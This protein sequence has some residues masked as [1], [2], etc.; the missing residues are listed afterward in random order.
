M[1]RTRQASKDPCV[2]AID[3]GTTGIKVG[4]FTAAGR[5]LA[6]ASREQR[7][8]FPGPGMVEQDP[9][10]TWQLQC[11]AVRE[12]VTTA[13]VSREAVA[14]LALSVQRGTVIAIDPDGKPL[15]NHIVWMDKR[16]VRQLDRL[17]EQLGAEAY[18]DI[19]GHPLVPYAG[20][21]KVLWLRHE[22]PEIFSRCRVVAPPQTLYLRWMGA[23]EWVCDTSAGTFFFPFEIRRVNWSNELLR[24][25]DVPGQKLPR[26]VP[27][28]TV[29]GT[30]SRG[31]AEACGLSPGTKVVAGGGDG[32][33]AAVGSGVT[34]AGRVMV[35]I[36][37][38]A[39]VQVFLPQPRLDPQRVLNCGAHVIPDAWEMEAHTQASGAVFRW[40]R[41][42]LGREELRQGAR[43][44]R[45]A[46]D[47]LIEQ[48]VR[49]P[50]GADGLMMLPTLNGSSAPVMRPAFKGAILGLRLSHTRAHLIRAL[51][52]GV[53]LELRWML[54]AIRDAGAAIDELRLVGGGSRSPIWN[55][56]HVSALGV[57]GKVLDI[58][59]AAVTGA[60]VCAAVA[61]EFYP[62][63]SA[64]SDAFVRVGRTYEPVA[65]DT[66]IYTRAYEAYKAAFA[67]LDR[68]QIFT[69]PAFG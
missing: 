26:V 63:F 9:I 36:G 17:R 7:L 12:A 11:E 41:D 51:L 69:L 47:L 18:Y 62:D 13:R 21:S 2:V 29:V 25:T 24:I 1:A 67:A 19:A 60:A 57:P 68:A 23:D 39:G 65:E 52:E 40:F 3:L 66:V 32:Q 22:A 56:I 28:T 45:S 5:L 33:C 58:A 20:V 27:S 34:A 8:L 30:L 50:A 38:A 14:A 16:G 4:V 37:T 10:H 44:G 31:A 15:T 59:D 55:Q 49:A 6:L 61:A 54:D 43:S 46:Y 53:S 42:E 48:A 35:N 64:A